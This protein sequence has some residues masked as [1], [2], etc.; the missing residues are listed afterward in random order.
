MGSVARIG[1]RVDAESVAWTAFSFP[2]LVATSF[3]RVLA[4]CCEVR[5]VLEES[6]CTGGGA[7]SAMLSAIPKKARVSTT[8]TRRMIAFR[9]EGSEGRFSVSRFQLLPPPLRPPLLPVGLGYVGLARCP[10]LPPGKPPKGFFFGVTGIYERLRAG[11]CR[12][13]ESDLSFNIISIEDEI[14][15]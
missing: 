4:G 14:H 6:C 5:P 7:P 10:L 8:I 1:A 12:K 15:R 3:G 13:G 11:R 2:N 9:F